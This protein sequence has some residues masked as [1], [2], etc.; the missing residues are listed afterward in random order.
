MTGQRETVL[1]RYQYDP[2]DRVVSC[3]PLSQQSIQRFY[4]KNRLATEIQGQVQRSIFEHEAHLLAQQQLQAGRVDSALLATD[5][6]RSVLHFVTASEHQ[7]PVY[8]PYGHRSPESGLTSL[9]GFNGERRDPVTGYYLLGNGYRAFNPVLMRF[10]SPDSLSPF[11]KGGLNAYA[12]CAGDPVNRVDPTGHHF[13]V[14]L[15]SGV[16]PRVL[17]QRVYS[18]VDSTARRWIGETVN[19]FSK[20]RPSYRAAKADE[21]IQT[22]N[23]ERLARIDEYN[24][25]R[26]HMTDHPPFTATKNHVSAQKSAIENFVGPRK[27]ENGP[28][29]DFNQLLENSALADAT[30]KRVYADNQALQ[31]A[32]VRMNEAVKKWQGATGFGAEE[33]KR[34]GQLAQTV[35]RTS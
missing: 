29:Q 11:G 19:A 1:C 34:I 25:I 14:V 23:T 17:A 9:L 26:S 6:Q 4:R 35:R 31:H 3:A 22:T 13:A 27:L 12:Y 2:L 16:T 24:K 20:L 18:I 30:L 5:R 32:R 21:L 8:C 33:L 10:N 15:I 28:T 7:Q